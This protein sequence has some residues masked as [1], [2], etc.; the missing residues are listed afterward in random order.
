MLKTFTL[1]VHI[2]EIYSEIRVGSAALDMPPVRC[3]SRGKTIKARPQ[4]SNGPA[5]YIDARERNPPMAIIALTS[6]NSV[7]GHLM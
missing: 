2:D 1:C 6:E 3:C 4:K 7:S 5:S